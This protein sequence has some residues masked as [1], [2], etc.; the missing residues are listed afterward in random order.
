V[1]VL[2]SD[3]IYKEAQ[4]AISD[5]RFHSGSDEENP[6]WRGWMSK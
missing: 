1:D 4:F 2:G 6:A 5:E 3:K